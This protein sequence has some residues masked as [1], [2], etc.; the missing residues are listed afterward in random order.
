MGRH[1][2]GDMAAAINCKAV[3]TL[4]L[5]S[6]ALNLALVGKSPVATFYLPV[7][8]VWNQLRAPVQT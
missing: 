3:L 2:L 5:I 4:F 6:M 1:R 8:R 7:T